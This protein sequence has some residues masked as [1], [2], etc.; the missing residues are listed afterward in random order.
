MINILSIDLDWIMEPSIQIYN[1]LS[2]EGEPIESNFLSKLDKGTILNADLKKYE[3]ISDLL[4]TKTGHLKDYDIKIANSHADLPREISYWRLDKAFTIYNVDHHHDCGYLNE[5]QSVTDAL[6]LTSCGNWVPRVLR[7]NPNFTKYIWISNKNSDDHIRADL[8]PHL[9][10]YEYTTDISVLQDIHFD[11]VF[12]CKSYA[13]IPL[14]Y[15]PM[16]DALTTAYSAFINKG[17]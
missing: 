13:W 16:L 5:E 3:Q 2:H 10:Q 9:P 1:S 6:H 12:I 4:F 11:K 17:C 14:E 7:L 8:E 15:R